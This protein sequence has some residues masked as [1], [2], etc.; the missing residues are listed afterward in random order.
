MEQIYKLL[1]GQ[2]TPELTRSIARGLETDEE[3]I[4]DAVS[5]IFAGF[6]VLTQVNGNTLHICNIFEEAGSLNI[7][8]RVDTLCG[9]PLAPEMVS[10]GDHF[11]QHVLGERATSFEAWVAM[12]TGLERTTVSELITILAPIFVGYIGHKVVTNR[13][14]IHKVFGLINMQRNLCR[15]FVPGLVV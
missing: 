5:F 14:S 13:W 10:V 7:A 6:L 4:Q 8:S 15:D 2:I 1:K 3:N 11:L 9:G 12:Q